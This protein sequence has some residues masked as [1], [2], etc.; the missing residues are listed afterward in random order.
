MTPGTVLQA[1]GFLFLVLYPLADDSMQRIVC[2]ILDRKPYVKSNTLTIVQ[3]DTTQYY[4]VP[5]AGLLEPSTLERLKVIDTIDKEIVFAISSDRG[6]LLQ[7]RAMR[8]QPLPR[9]S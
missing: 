5:G 3:S 8:N 9:G 1:Q 6:L 2:T 4:H 7:V